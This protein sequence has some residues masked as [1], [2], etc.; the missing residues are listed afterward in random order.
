M[1][2]DLTGFDRVLREDADRFTMTVCVYAAAS[3]RTP[4]EVAHEALGDALARLTE[5]G[6]LGTAV[7]DE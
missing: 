3:G 1:S 4:Y 6:S 2:D 5:D 7:D